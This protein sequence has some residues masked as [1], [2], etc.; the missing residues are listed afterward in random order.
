MLRGQIK[1]IDRIKNEYR[2]FIPDVHTDNLIPTLYPVAVSN[3]GDTTNIII[4]YNL[5]DWVWIEFEK[6]NIHFPVIVGSYNDFIGYDKNGIFTSYSSDQTSSFNSVNDI[7]HIINESTLN[8]IH[9]SKTVDN[10]LVKHDGD[11][12]LKFD[13]LNYK[14]LLQQISDI[15]NAITELQTVV[16]SALGVP[17][18]QLNYL[19]LTNNVLPPNSTSVPPFSTMSIIKGAVI[20][21]QTQVKLFSNHVHLTGGIPTTPPLNPVVITQILK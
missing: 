14:S 19:N 9:V 12:Y 10:I 7:T 8:G 15:N 18:S 17:F 2:V 3:L 6:D 5:N 16:T 1:S 13:T 21:L 11:V 20:E 4:N